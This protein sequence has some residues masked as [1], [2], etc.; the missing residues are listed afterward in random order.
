MLCSHFLN[1]VVTM[2]F[3]HFSLSCFWTG[4]LGL[5]LVLSKDGSRVEKGNSNVLI[6]P[7]DNKRDSFPV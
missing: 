7:R 6:S 2:S 4:R 3:H 5:F 1:G